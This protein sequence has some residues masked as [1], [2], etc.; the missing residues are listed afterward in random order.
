MPVTGLPMVLENMVMAIMKTHK[1]KTWNLFHEENGNITFRL[2]FDH[3]EES[4]E[5]LYSEISSTGNHETI[6]FKK[7]NSKQ[8]SR[9]KVRSRKRRRV[10]QSTSSIET[11]RR[12]LLFTDNEMDISSPIG[13]RIEVNES[14]IDSP[15]LSVLDPPQILEEPSELDNPIS[16]TVEDVKV[17][18]HLPPVLDYSDE[19]KHA[20]KVES[21]EST[22][23]DS[24]DDYIDCSSD[25]SSG[26]QLVNQNMWAKIMKKLDEFEEKMP[27]MKDFEDFQFDFQSD[28]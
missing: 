28:T 26:G 11:N 17:D 10:R 5:Q 22:K 24:E 27:K 15:C 1:L 7:K 8:I 13:D 2:K 16:S 25:S 3:I 19:D 20:D 12:E 23:E 21:T 6:S 14:V 4:P 18:V 9:D